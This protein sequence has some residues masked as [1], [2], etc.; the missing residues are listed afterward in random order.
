MK[1]MQRAESG[2]APWVAER[3]E[4]YGN[5]RK[6]M[7]DQKVKDRRI[8]RAKIKAEWSVNYNSQV[9]EQ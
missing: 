9:T 5:N 7:A 3:G 6:M 1:A 4:R 8:R 2:E